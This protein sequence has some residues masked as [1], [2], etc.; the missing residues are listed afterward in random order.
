MTQ[1]FKHRTVTDTG[2]ES[3]SLHECLDLFTQEEELG[4]EDLWYGSLFSLNGAIRLL[5]LF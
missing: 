4:A 3:V 2:H 5:G 1:E